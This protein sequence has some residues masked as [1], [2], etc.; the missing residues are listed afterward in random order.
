MIE[1]IN[2]NQAGFWIAAGF[3]MLAAEVLIFGFGTIVFLF[4]GIGAL[5]TGLFMTLGVLPQSWVAGIACFG[6][7]TG[8]ASAVLWSPFK[9]MQNSGSPPSQQSSDLIGYSFVLGQDVNSQATGIHRYSGVDWTV[10]LEDGVQDELTTGQKVVVT[11][12]D[13]GIF[14]VKAK[15]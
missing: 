15:P 6:I 3:F 13:V 14:R 4:A 7:S 5:I 12:V 9:K 2:A 1:Y 10:K 8:V 11:S